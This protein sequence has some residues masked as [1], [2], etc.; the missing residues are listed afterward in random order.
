MD[1]FTIASWNVGGVYFLRTLPRARDQAEWIP[2]PVPAII[3]QETFAAVQQK[4]ARNLA[5]SPR[6]RK[7]AYLF[8]A[9]RLRCGRC[10]RGMT[11][12][13]SCGLQ[14][15]RCYSQVQHAP[16]EPFC[17]RSVRATDIEPL[18]W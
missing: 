8:V 9:G 17:Q 3:S 18:V 11:G 7:H 1:D 10:G 15:Y 6:N 16:G 5:L 2:L 12:Y 14:R 13:T 4:L